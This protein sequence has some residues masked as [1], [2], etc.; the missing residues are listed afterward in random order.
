MLRS[1]LSRK[2]IPSLAFAILVGILSVAA[3]AEDTN[4]KES[5]PILR[6]ET[7]RKTNDELQHIATKRVEPTLPKLLK[8]ARLMDFVDVAVTVD[9]QGSVTVLRSFC[10][11]NK[12]LWNKR[13]LRL[14]PRFASKVARVAGGAQSEL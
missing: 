12:R 13:A 10:L 3:V 14:W 9:E 7:I 8:G 11:T 5:A 6:S 4:M 2:K 1:R